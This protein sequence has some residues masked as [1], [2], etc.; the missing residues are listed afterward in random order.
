MEL[1]V[2]TYLPKTLY[3][4][5]VKLLLKKNQ[6]G[7]WKSALVF[8]IF[9]KRITLSSE[10][11]LEFVKLLLNR[12]GYSDSLSAAYRAAEATY[13]NYYT[14]NI[15]RVISKYFISRLN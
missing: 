8:P 5:C 12:R 15:K 1:S 6:C 14:E 4:P 13:L 11:I 3:I 2:N 9:Q 10:N 7:Q